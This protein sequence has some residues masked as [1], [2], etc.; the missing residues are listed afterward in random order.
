MYVLNFEKSLE[1]EPAQCCMMSDH[2]IFDGHVNLSTVPCQC[3]SL[4]PTKA[5]AHQELPSHPSAAA[6]LSALIS[7]ILIGSL[8]LASSYLFQCIRDREHAN[9]KHNIDRVEQGLLKG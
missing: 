4:K 5:L 8:Q 1:V 6:I 9:S 7:S 3:N 2:L